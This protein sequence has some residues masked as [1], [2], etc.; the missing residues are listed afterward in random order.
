LDL[1]ALRAS[2]WWLLE[3]SNSLLS[4]GAGFIEHQRVML[5]LV[6]VSM[7]LGHALQCV[8][9]AGSTCCGA[10]QVTSPFI[11]GLPHRGCVLPPALEQH[12]LAGTVHSGLQVYLSVS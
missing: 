1:I 11:L 3:A 12:S 7:V 8:W 6:L 10:S 2:N 9:L 4:S 5:M